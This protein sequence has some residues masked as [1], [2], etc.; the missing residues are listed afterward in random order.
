[1]RLAGRQ[2]SLL[3]RSNGIT[4]GNLCTS[5][6]RWLSPNDAV[7]RPVHDALLTPANQHLACH[8]AQ[9]YERRRDQHD[10]YNSCERSCVRYGRRDG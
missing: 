4:I 10:E 5:A 6:L 3:L 1:M 2:W 9:S 8:R 7:A